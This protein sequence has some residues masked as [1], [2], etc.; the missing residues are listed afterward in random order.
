MNRIIVLVPPGNVKEAARRL[1]AGTLPV[2]ENAT[3]GERDCDQHHGRGDSLARRGLAAA[4]SGAGRG[5][6]LA[7]STGWLIFHIAFE[8]AILLTLGPTVFILPYVVQRRQNSWTGVVI[9]AVLN[10]PGFLA[11]A[12]G[13]V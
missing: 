3:P 6:W 13:M 12:F 1:G 2:R 5:A 9:H 8:P 11:V 7:N 4:G 10:G